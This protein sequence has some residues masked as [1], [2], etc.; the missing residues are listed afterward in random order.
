M[1]SCRRVCSFL[2][3]R[4]AFD[5]ILIKGSLKYMGVAAP[6]LGNLSMTAHLTCNLCAV[7]PVA[8]FVEI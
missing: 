2:S 5:R 3:V 1:E 4:L 6:L 7:L 8:K